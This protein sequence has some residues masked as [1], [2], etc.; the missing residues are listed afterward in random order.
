[1]VN[2][3]VRRQMD[4]A[5]EAMRSER[6]FE[7][8]SDRS[9]SCALPPEQMTSDI[10]DLSV[11]KFVH[12]AH[13]FDPHNFQCRLEQ[14]RK[15]SQG[16]RHSGLQLDRILVLAQRRPR[17]VVMKERVVIQEGVAGR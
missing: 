15:T 14:P 8:F 10:R 3:I 16:V 11:E 17:Y 5:I 4:A 9:K 12:P 6:L 13:V 7:W 2:R 1:M